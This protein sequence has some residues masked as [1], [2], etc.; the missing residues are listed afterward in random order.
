MVIDRIGNVNNITGA[1][2]IQNQKSKEIKKGIGED[3]VSISREAQK[4]QELSRAGEIVKSAA[5]IRPDRVKEV[6]EKLNRGDYDKP[7]N[8]LLEKVAEKI[9][10]SLLRL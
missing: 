7:D 3:T 4:A 2:Q 6:R 8:E 9:A 1:D 5:D 10:Q